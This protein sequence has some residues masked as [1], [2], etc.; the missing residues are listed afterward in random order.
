MSLTLRL[1]NALSQELEQQAE[2]IGVAPEVHAT[3]LLALAA[4]VVGEDRTLGAADPRAQLADRMLRMIRSLLSDGARSEADI[5][6]LRQLEAL[7]ARWAREGNPQAA[8]GDEDARR[9]S[10]R[11]KYAHIPGTSEDF[12][13]R[14][15]EEID[16]EDGRAA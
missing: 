2:R 6:R 12:A 7:L 9:P 10:A 14:K 8:P 11:G 3:D 4:G 5:E 13:R 16:R 15:Q 1:P